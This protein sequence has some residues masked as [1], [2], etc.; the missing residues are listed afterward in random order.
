MAVEGWE[1]RHAGDDDADELLGG[2][3]VREMVS[4]EVKG[5]LN[6]VP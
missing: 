6:G 5:E 2:T 3:V 1:Y 4:V